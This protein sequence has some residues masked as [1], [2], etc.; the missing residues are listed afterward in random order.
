MVAGFDFALERHRSVW[1][2]AGTVPMQNLKGRPVVSH[3]YKSNYRTQGCHAELHSQAFSTTQLDRSKSS[4]KILLCYAK[5]MAHFP[6]ELSPSS[7]RMC[8][9]EL[10]KGKDK[11]ASKRAL[12]GKVSFIFSFPF[13]VMPTMWSPYDSQLGLNWQ[14]PQRLLQSG[15]EISSPYFPKT[16]FS[17]DCFLVTCSLDLHIYPV[18]ALL[19]LCNSILAWFN[20]TPCM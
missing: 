16:P 8:K 18:T 12:G 3:W 1:W 15:K 2:T 9:N 7:H 17:F 20:S 19:A 4:H 11:F 13:F 5:R 6:A 14:Q 10:G